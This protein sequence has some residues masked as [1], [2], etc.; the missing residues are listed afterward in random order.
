MMNVFN[1]HNISWVLH[2]GW[3]IGGICRLDAT[4]PMPDAKLRF[5]LWKLQDMSQMG[6]LASLL[7]RFVYVRT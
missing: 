3:L 7:Y 4:K 5:Y 1:C 6:S 2:A